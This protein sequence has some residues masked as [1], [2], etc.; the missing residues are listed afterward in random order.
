MATD[1]ELKAQLADLAHQAEEAK[2]LEVHAVIVEIRTKV[3]EY[4]LT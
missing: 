4:G 2:A 3:A 1:H